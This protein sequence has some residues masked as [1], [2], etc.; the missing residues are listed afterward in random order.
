MG[1]VTEPDVATTCPM[2]SALPGSYSWRYPV[3]DTAGDAGMTTPGRAPSIPASQAPSV[4]ATPSSYDVVSS[5]K[6]HTFPVASWA[7][8]S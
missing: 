5:P 8:Q 4:L 7:Y 3:S 6:Y 1:V 2:S